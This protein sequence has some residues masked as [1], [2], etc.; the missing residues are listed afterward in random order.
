M[1]K[2]ILSVRLMAVILFMFK[3]NAF[4]LI[5]KLEDESLTEIEATCALLNVMVAALAVTPEIANE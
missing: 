4:K 5:I 2:G 1:T 3:L